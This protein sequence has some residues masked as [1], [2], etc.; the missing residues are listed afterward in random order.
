VCGD[1]GSGKSTF[2]RGAQ[3]YLESVGFTVPAF[4][5]ASKHT[6]LNQFDNE[7]KAR[8]QIIAN[9]EHVGGSIF[10]DEINTS[11]GG[12]GAD[13]Y[14]YQILLSLLE[15]SP[16]DRMRVCLP[17]VVDLAKLVWFFVGTHGTS[18]AKSEEYF[19]TLPPATKGPD[20]GSRI[21]EH[22]ELPP[23]NDVFERIVSSIAM[24]KK[25]LPTLDEIDPRLLLSLAVDDSNARKRRGRIDEIISCCTNA[26]KLALE[27]DR[28]EPE[29][30]RFYLTYQTSFKQ[31]DARFIRLKEMP[32]DQ[33]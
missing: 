4:I 8:L 6:T 23:S 18:K 25:G 19:R 20:F 3:S 2:V 7:V 28:R 15:F 24:M 22:V 12:V 21:Y 27:D 10:I 17:G 14:V 33:G 11:I 30:R 29:A 1:P 9:T 13:I 26:S 32:T 31:L 16:T 5:D